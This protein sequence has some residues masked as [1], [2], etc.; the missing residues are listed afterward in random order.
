[1]TTI[2]EGIEGQEEALTLKSLG[3][4]A[5]QGYYFAKPLKDADALALLTERNDFSDK[6]AIT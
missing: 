4:E 6:M 5:A 2:A 1:M 3:C